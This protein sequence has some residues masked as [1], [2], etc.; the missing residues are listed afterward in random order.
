MILDRLLEFSNAQDVSQGTGDVASTNVVDWGVASGIPSSA[1]GGGK[2]DMGV[3]DPSLKFV[4]QMVEGLA[5]AGGTGT[6][7]IHLQGAPDN[8]AGSPDTFVTWWSSDAYTVTEATAGARLF[9]IAMPRP[10]Q[11]A[12]IPRYNRLLYSIGGETTTAGTVSAYLVLDRDDQVYN[13]TDN[14]ILGGYQA[15]INVAN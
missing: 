8:G 15:G 6:L 12:P 10:P 5:S 1:N 4:V 11:G 3:G 14:S 13:G 9:D 2:R 7:Q